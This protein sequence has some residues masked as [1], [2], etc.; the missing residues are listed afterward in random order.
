MF[1]QGRLI[2]TLDT[3]TQETLDTVTL[4]TDTRENFVRLPHY[5]FHYM[6]EHLLWFTNSYQKSLSF[7]I[8]K[9]KIGLNGSAVAQRA[10]A[11]YYK[12][13]DLGLSLTR[14]HFLIFSC[15]SP[16]SYHE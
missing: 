10:S 11:L 16:L 3:L 7:Q 5:M 12:S 14:G 8:K 2:V 4:D 1:D 15:H 9:L 13:G 6:S